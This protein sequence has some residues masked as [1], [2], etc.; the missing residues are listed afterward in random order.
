MAH[1]KADGVNKEYK[2]LKT[3][4]HSALAK[5]RD[6]MDSNEND[7]ANA[8]FAFAYQMR[9]TSDWLWVHA[10]GREG[11][12]GHAKYLELSRA[13]GKLAA[14]TK[15]LTDDEKAIIKKRIEKIKD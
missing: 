12:E 4:A 15:P 2:E 10:I 13:F 1:C 9:C 3:L 5:G 7:K 11:D 6:Q 14:G 8:S